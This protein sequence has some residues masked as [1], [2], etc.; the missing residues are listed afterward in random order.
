[1][2]KSMD[3]LERMQAE[4]MQGGGQ[5]RIDA[6][7]AKGK[8]TARERVGLLLDDGSF[9][10]LGQ[11]VTHRSNLFGLD[12]Q[13]FLGDGVV[14]GYGTVNGRLV[15]V[16]S[17]DFTVLGGSLAE[18][19][20]EKICRVMDLALD[21]GAPVI[22]L[23]DSGGA[24]IQ[25]GVVS[26]GGYADIFH[27][28]VQASGVVPQISAILGPCAG[29]AVYSP[30]LTDFI[31]MTEGTSYMFVTGP[32]VVKTVTHEEVTAEQLGGAST[33][34]S[35]SGV[36]HLTC[37]N[38]VAVIDQVK[39]LLSYLPQNCEEQPAMEA[40]GVNS[41]GAGGELRPALRDV[42]PESAMQ[43]YD[44]RTVAAEILDADSFLEI[45]P[46]YAPNIIVG[47]GRIAGRSIGLVANQPA[48]LAG[49]LDINASKKA[50][51]FVRTCDAFNV[52]LL[53]LEDVPGFLPG[54]DQEWG[55]IIS[56]GAKLLYAFSE[57]TVPRVTVI[58]R[59]AYGGAYDVMN[60]KHIG[61]DMNFAWPSAEI[62]VMGAKGAAEIIFRKEISEAD[63]PAGKLA[64][65][66]AEYAELFAHPYRAASRGY[67]DE[68]ID[69]AQTRQKLIR[70]FDMLRNKSV[71]R[72]KRKHGN[73][74]L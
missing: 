51:R 23:N 59:K 39:A 5:K 33:H 1:M 17:Q 40:Y 9:E 18:A 12:K 22:G 3:R 25:E 10:E 73:P 61:A 72:P 6:Q 21:N 55:G 35:K 7:H 65:K 68:V 29:G 43:P 67:V 41:G 70:A 8:L 56:N 26:L 38:E 45:Q 32:N 62:A 24:R 64:E 49:V 54:T 66:E 71:A 53:V 19:H 4:A 44:I 36:A 69:P 30:A 27:R 42:I 2:E 20:A 48:Y 50:A 15:Y 74:P 31:V 60:S 46:D 28:N 57:A 14:T 52:P 47:F 34:A 58:T 13:H 16:F 37:P 63:D 11:L